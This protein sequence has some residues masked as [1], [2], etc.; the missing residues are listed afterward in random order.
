[1]RRSLRFLLPEYLLTWQVLGLT[2]GWALLLHFLDTTSTPSGNVAVRVL[3]LLA[4]HLLLFGIIWLLSRTVLPHIPASKTPLALLAIIVI[5][6]ALRGLCFAWL[7]LEAGVQ[8]ELEVGVRVGSSVMNVTLALV[9]ATIAV[10]HVRNHYRTKS[11]LLTRENQLRRLQEQAAAQLRSVD[12]EL[13]ASVEAELIE[14]IK[15]IAEA[16]AAVALEILRE[17]ID[18]VVRPLSH[19]LDSQV[20]KW[21]PPNVPES[22]LRIDWKRAAIEATN[23]REIRPIVI[24]VAL[25][26]TSLPTMLARYGLPFALGLYATAIATGLG[27]LW[28]ARYAGGAAAARMSEQL[29]WTVFAVCLLLSGQIMG[30]VSYAWTRGTAT[31]LGY[32]FLVAPFCLIIGFVVALATT[33]RRLASEIE[34]DLDVTNRELRWTVAR[35]QEIQRQR[36]RALVHVLHGHVQAAMGASFLRI[37][38]ELDQPERMQDLLVSIE[39]DLERAI[40]KLSSHLDE[41]DDLPVVVRRIATTWT[42]IARIEHAIAPKTLDALRGDPVCLTSLNDLITELCFNSV[43]HGDASVIEV[44]VT[45]TQPRAVQLEVRDNGELT[46]S[47][48]GGGLGTQLL[49]NCAIEWS[50]ASVEGW[51]ITS[52]LIPLVSNVRI[53]ELVDRGV[54]TAALMTEAAPVK[55]T[56]VT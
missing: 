12:D 46:I 27:A 16:D 9:L 10:G 15:P 4:S 19:Y 54:G 55:N 6:A 25:I 14:A 21:Q 29:R 40:S 20:P 43:K 32:V 28:F 31:P 37:Q 13:V 44:A 3:A 45:V 17:S 7:L 41:P 56:P 1:M 11:L 42:G 33:A 22:D 26:A 47:H 36:K 52:V 48:G 24:L 23:P 2:L 8:T 30:L 35:S 39:S 50:R 5:A 49:D 51:T 18:D 38:N 34:A 53:S